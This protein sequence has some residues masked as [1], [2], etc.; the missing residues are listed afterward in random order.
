LLTAVVKISRSA[1]F[2]NES[3]AR[4]IFTEYFTT[5][6]SKASVCQLAAI[7]RIDDKTQ[8]ITS[9]V[10]P[11]PYPGDRRFARAGITSATALHDFLDEVLRLTLQKNYMELSKMFRYPFDVEVNGAAR[12]IGSEADFRE[13][14]GSIVDARFRTLIEDLVA[15][16]DFIVMTHGIMLNKEGDY[17]IYEVYGSLLLQPVGPFMRP[18]D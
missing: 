6:V 3:V 7:L 13:N 4:S 5:A 1:V 11:E 15:H 8:R 14:A 9:L 17:W 2:T 16:R 12:R 10:Y 18:P